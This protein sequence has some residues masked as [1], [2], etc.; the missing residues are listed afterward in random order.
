MIKIIVYFLKTQKDPV[1]NT[2]MHGCVCVS[3]DV[4]VHIHD[5]QRGE[6]ATHCSLFLTALP[7]KIKQRDDIKFKGLKVKIRKKF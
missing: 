5:V 3:M 1:I 6:V 7:H 4:H 2:C